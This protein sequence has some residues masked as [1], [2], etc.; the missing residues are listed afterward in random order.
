MLDLNLKALR[1][2]LWAPAPVPSPTLPPEGGGSKKRGPFSPPPPRGEGPG[3]GS[4]PGAQPAQPAPASLTRRSP[5]HRTLS[6]G[7]H[8]ADRPGGPGVVLAVRHPVS[9]VMVAARKDKAETLSAAMDSRFGLACPPGGESVTNADVALHWCGF[10][11]WY[12]VSGSFAEGAL[13]E[14]L[15][16]DMAGLASVFDQSHGRVIFH[17]EGPRARDVLAKGTALDLH[18]RVFG[19]GRSAVTQMAHVGVHVAQVGA[20]A[21]EVSLFRGFAESLWEWLGEMSDEFGY[22]VR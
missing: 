9:I 19:P 20:D 4:M 22:E 7:R 21:F 6:P 12:A 13:Y 17:L 14:T 3:V 11:Q 16:D 18:P 5:L 15:R 8:G 2:A 10:E 1:A